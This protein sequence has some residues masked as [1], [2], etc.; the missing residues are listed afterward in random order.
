MKI[1]FKQNE[2]AASPFDELNICDCYLKQLYIDSDAS[3]ITRKT[4]H[5]TGFE[6]HIITNGGQTY[7]I[8]NNKYCIREGKFLLISPFVAHRIISAEPKTEKYSLTFICSELSYLDECVSG[9]IPSRFFEN[10][11]FISDEYQNSKA[12]SARLI[13]NSV[14]ECLM[15]LLRLS[16]LR[17]THITHENHTDDFR[18][19]YVKK[20]ISDN[21]ENRITVTDIASYCYISAKQITRIFLKHEGIT[22]AQ[23]IARQRILHIQKLLENSDLTLNEISER[24][25]FQNEY[26][27]NVFV[28]KHLGMP[29][30]TYRRMHR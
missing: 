23:Y 6:I 1:Y 12:T 7:E 19:E 8:G 30:G 28:R 11:R 10:I 4:H 18:L 13:E 14:F 27:F 21:I 26:Y 22:P 3:K 17:E 2:S 20:Y 9:E 15:M 25:N 16:G 29:P 24:M 5:H